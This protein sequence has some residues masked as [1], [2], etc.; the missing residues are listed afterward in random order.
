MKDLGKL[1]YFLGVSIVQDD[2]H[3]FINQSAYIQSLLKKYGMENS[4]P[5]LTPIEV[6]CIL[7]KAVDDSD[8]FDLE[9]YQ[10]AV[11]SL[12]Y[13]STRTHWSAVKRIFRYLRGTDDLGILYSKDTTRSC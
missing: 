9:T 13:L 10:S 6:N 3:I 7:E 4:K 2:D 5:V 8:L 11:G 12:M 1:N